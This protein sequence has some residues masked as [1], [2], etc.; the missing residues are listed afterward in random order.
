LSASSRV[1]VIGRAH[2]L[3]ASLRFVVLD[4][5]IETAQL[6]NQTAAGEFGY[7]SAR[8]FAD[9]AAIAAEADQ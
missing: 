9:Q 7:G 1:V 4:D 3:G 8:R 2:P 6:A 5:L